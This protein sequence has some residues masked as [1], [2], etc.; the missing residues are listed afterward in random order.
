M[1]KQPD[2]TKTADLLDTETS[3]RGRPRLGAEAQTATQRQAT[4][5][6]R[7]KALGEGGKSGDRRLSVWLS[8]DAHASLTRLAAHQGTSQR[9]LLEKILIDL[10]KAT[11]SQLDESQLDTYYR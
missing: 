10:D 4:Y 1:A 8:Y 11:V 2:D 9:E 5:R 6:A 7:R 3:K